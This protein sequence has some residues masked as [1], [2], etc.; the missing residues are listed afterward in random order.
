ML[1]FSVILDF[2]RTSVDSSYTAIFENQVVY[3]LL[4]KQFFIFIISLHLN[5]SLDLN[6]Y[7]KN[8]VPSKRQLAC[9]HSAPNKVK[10]IPN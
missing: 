2:Y 8:S 4:K 1:D 3:E 5:S 7:F 10:I 9:S 6:F